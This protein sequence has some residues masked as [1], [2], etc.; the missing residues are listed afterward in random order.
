MIGD[1]GNTWKRPWLK[2]VAERF[3]VKRD[4]IVSSKDQ[5]TADPIEDLS[6]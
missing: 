4:N 6:P 5:L 3:E 2:R 1:L